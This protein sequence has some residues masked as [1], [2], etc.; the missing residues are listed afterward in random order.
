M[1]RK[2][3]H[4]EEYFFEHFAMHRHI[5]SCVLIS[6]TFHSLFFSFFLEMEIRQVTNNSLSEDCIACTSVATHSTRVKQASR[7]PS[8]E[9]EESRRQVQDVE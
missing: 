2:L 1:V 4:C 3:F 6:D 9:R 8:F 7:I 5:V